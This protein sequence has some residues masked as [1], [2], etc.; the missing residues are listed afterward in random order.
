MMRSCVSVGSAFHAGKIVKIFLRDHVAAA[1]ECGILR[2]D[3]RG[4][5]H[6]LPTRIFGAVDEAQEVAVIEV[7]KAVHLVDRRDRVAELRHDLRRDLETQVHPLGA[8]MK[9]EVSR[10]CDR[11]A[12]SGPELAERVKF[13]RARVAEQPVPGVGADAHDAGE[14]GLEIAK[15]NRANQARKVRAE[16]PHGVDI[17]LALVDG[18]DQEDRGARQRRR[19]RLC[20]DSVCSEVASAMRSLARVFMSGRRRADQG[21][22]F[23][24]TPRR[25]RF[26]RSRETFV[27][28]RGV[29]LTAPNRVAFEGHPMFS[30]D[31]IARATELVARYRA[32]GLMAATAESCTGG[33]IAGLLTEIPGSSNMLERGFVVYSNAAKQELLGVPAETLASHGAVSDETAVAMA[34]GALRASR[35]EVAVSVTGIAGPGRRNG[36]K[37]RSAL[38]ISPAPAAGSRRSRARSG[39]ATSVAGRCGSLPSRSASIFSRRR[40]AA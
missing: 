26:P 6:R 5:D 24:R 29:S 27:A 3:E 35:A 4:V 16:R 36:W 8:D 40:S 39:S 28:G 1:G 30:P 25:L 10:R 38:S 15:F 2:A 21:L 34:E 31:L 20:N 33:L 18:H 7:A 12:R 22:S 13:G 14:A 9:Q 17:V 11:V 32:A 37:S 23:D 19:Y